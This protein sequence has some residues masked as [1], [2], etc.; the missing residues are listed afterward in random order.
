MKHCIEE[1]LL[2]FHVSM[3]DSILG[4]NMINKV[5]TSIIILPLLIVPLFCCCIKEASAATVGEEHCHD[6]KDSHSTNHEQSNSENAH[7]CDCSQLLSTTG[8]HSAT[9]QADFVSQQQFS[10][11]PSLVEPFSIVSLK[12][13]LCLAYLGPPGRQSAVPFYTL[14]HSLRI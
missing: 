5:I 8:D 1:Y 13:S 12:G 7:S 10:I 3:I 6:V 2:S 14:Y 4:R 11:A 9:I